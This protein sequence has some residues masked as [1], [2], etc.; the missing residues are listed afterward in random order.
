M[1]KS[2]Q[3]QSVLFKNEKNALL[4][5]LDN[6]ANALRVDGGKHIASATVL[7]GDASPEPIFTSQEISAIQERYKGSMALR[8]VF[9]NEN[10]GTAKGHNR[11]VKI[12][13]KEYIMVMNPDIIVNPRI[14][15]QLMQPFGDE[16]VGLTEARQTPIEHHKQ[17]DEKTGETSWA[18]TACVVFP[19]KVFEK[20]GGFDEKTF[21]MYC[22]DLDFS[23]IIRLAGYKVIYVPA[24]VVFH[25]KSISAQAKWQPTYA[26]RYYS[27]EAALLMAHKWSNPER[28]Q[29]LLKQ[30][31]DS[32]GEIELKVVEEYRRREK[33]GT[34]PAPV[35]PE[36]KVAEFVGDN[37]GYSRFTM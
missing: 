16:R 13:N 23:W 36:H 18:S 28:V 2:I 31:K 27:A 26:E 19:R 24:A 34:L 14:F 9:F 7:W 35:D 22:D 5:A 15:A 17:Y 21:F 8:Y 37:Y 29:K 1:S 4:R 33:S 20:V 10:T 11:L 30:F 25:D 32:R 3:I 12:E 6:I